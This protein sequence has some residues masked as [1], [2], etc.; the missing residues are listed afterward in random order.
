MKQNIGFIGLG[1]LGTPIAIN[2]IE[3]GHRLHVYNRTSSKAEPL[4]EKGAIV[5]SSIAELAQQC[6]IVF[7]MVSDDAALKS[8]CNGEEGLFSNLSKD[9]LHISMSTILPRTASD[10]ASLHEEHHQR[11]LASPV[12]GRPEAAIAKKLNFAVSGNKKDMAAGTPLLKD[13]GGA[14]VWEFGE[15]IRAANTVKLCGNFLIASALEAI[16]ESVHLAEN[17]GIDAQQMW[18]MFTQTL[19]SS[20]IYINYGN[21][22][23]QQKFEPAAFTMKLGLKDINLVMQQ[24]SIAGVSMPAAHL[25]QSKMQRLIEQGKGNIDWCAVGAMEAL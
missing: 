8:I 7:T 18:S 9:S 21:I 23:L 12:F 17:S 3:S 25:L 19:F 13:A 4:R 10:I 14:A 1:S 24:A 6:N 11:Y 5:C 20:P 16:G 15:D 22:I 2:L